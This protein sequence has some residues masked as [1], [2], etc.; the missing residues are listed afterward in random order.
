MADSGLVELVR[1]FEH[2]E[3]ICSVARCSLDFLRKSGDRDQVH[4]RLCCAM[5]K[6]ADGGNAE[7]SR[8][9]HFAGDMQVLVVVYG[10]ITHA[11]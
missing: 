1:A 3:N 2:A 8:L 6:R 11:K 10:N 7:L 5:I 4:S 9:L